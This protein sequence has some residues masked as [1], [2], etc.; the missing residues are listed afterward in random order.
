MNLK[1]EELE[2][3]LKFYSEKLARRQLDFEGN[4]RNLKAYTREI[5]A[6]MDEIA[7]EL[8]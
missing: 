3:L 1:P 4:P 8:P 7:K 5:I 6:R 2:A